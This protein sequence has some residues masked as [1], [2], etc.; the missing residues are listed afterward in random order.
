MWAGGARAHPLAAWLAL[1]L[2]VSAALLAREL[3]ARARDSGMTPP[4][5]EW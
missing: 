2:C 3:A 1:P 4:P 5:P